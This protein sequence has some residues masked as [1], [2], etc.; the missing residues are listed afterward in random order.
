MLLA[1][2]VGAFAADKPTSSA[3]AASAPKKTTKSAAKP[4]STPARAPLLTQQQLQDCIKQKD[5]LRT[6]TDDAL[7]EKESLA[8][9]RTE[10]TNAGTTLA[11]EVA[12]LD[13]TSQEQ[14]DAYNAKVADRDKLVTAYQAKVNAFNSKADAV[15]ATKEAYLANC[16]SRRYDEQDLP[17]A[18]KTKK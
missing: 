4:A 12:T 2:G 6:Q 5:A 11:D 13:R 14:V 17:P 3:A 8:G 16:E 18:A 10:I 1:F 7:K 15:N 9:A